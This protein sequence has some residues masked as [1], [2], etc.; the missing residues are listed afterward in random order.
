M[1]TVKLTELAALREISLSSLF[2]MHQTWREGQVFSMAAPR[3]Q[4][5]LLW[6]CGCA[7]SFSTRKGRTLHVPHGG[8][9]YIPQG[10]EYEL[11]FHTCKEAPSTVLVEF[12]LSDGQ[13]FVLAEEIELLL[14]QLEDRDVIAT[15]ERLANDFL[16]PSK[17]WLDIQSEVF[18]LLAM[19]AGIEEGKHLQSGG[20]HTI[21]KGIRYL[22]TD[23]EQ[24][25]SIDEIAAMCAVSP[26]YFRKMFHAYAGVSPS[27][28][29]AS[30]RI[31]Q[32]K[33]LLC[34]SD[35]SVEEIAERLHFDNPSYFC[36]VF[37]KAVGLPPSTYRKSK[38]SFEK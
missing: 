20:I 2:S 6:F 27:A 21:Q 38:Q 3:K 16:K 4:S 10:S 35:L 17:P 36:R 30:R 5:A 19:V 28:Y 34:H 12:C 26:V 29:R 14:S 25:L 22:Q 37:K 32:A 31:E 13:P 1:H 15:L 23:E 18:R 9:V 24:R 7:G 8:L 33:D 11:L